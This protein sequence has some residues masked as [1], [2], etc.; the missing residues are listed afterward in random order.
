[1]I[2]F[3]RKMT[4]SKRNYEIDEQE[5]LTIIKVCKKWRYYVEDFKY[6]V[7]VI[8][9]Y[10]NLKNFFINKNLNRKKF[11]WWKNLTKLDFK[12]EYRF[13]KNNFVDDSFRRRDYENQTAKENKLKNENLNLKKWALIKNNA[14]FKNKNEKNK[15]EKIFSLSCR[16]C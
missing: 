7:Q 16:N 3:F 2:F 15:E 1:M 10:A 4:I 6:F 5:M 12:I 11:K 9:D 13:D 8:I 14:S